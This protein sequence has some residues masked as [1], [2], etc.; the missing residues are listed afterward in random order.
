MGKL[1][2]CM[3]KSALHRAT[4]LTESRRALSRSATLSSRKIT[5]SA[6]FVKLWCFFMCGI[7]GWL[8]ISWAH[9]LTCGIVG[10]L[11]SWTY[12]SPQGYASRRESPRPFSRYTP[13][14]PAH[15]LYT[16][17]LRARTLFIGAA[18]ETPTLRVFLRRA[19]LLTESSPALSR[20]RT[21]ETVLV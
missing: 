6:S 4:L 16:E 13:V 20:G 18:F 9:G 17:G 3:Y 19:T 15:L 11:V 2:T 10:L 14:V 7:V 21:L 8:L 5:Q 12:G 1:E